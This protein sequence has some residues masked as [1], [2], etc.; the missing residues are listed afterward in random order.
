MSNIMKQYLGI[1]VER[2]VAAIEI[3]Y[4]ILSVY[5]SKIEKK[6]KTYGLSYSKRLL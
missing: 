6:T 5:I 1:G 3:F 2:N 4:F